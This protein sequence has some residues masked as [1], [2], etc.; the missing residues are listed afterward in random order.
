MGVCYGTPSHRYYGEGVCGCVRAMAHT[1]SST[2]LSEGRF[3]Y[4]SIP[5]YSKREIRVPWH[6]YGEGRDVSG[7]S[8]APERVS[9]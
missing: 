2:E 4:S 6:P 1:H 8:R 5:T 9:V 7:G 3:V